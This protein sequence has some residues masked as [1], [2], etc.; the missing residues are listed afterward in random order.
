MI[1]PEQVT[2]QAHLEVYVNW[3]YYQLAVY[4]AVIADLVLF[5]WRVA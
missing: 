1:W 5:K 4:A 2:E 3:I